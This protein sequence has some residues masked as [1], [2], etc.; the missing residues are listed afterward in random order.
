MPVR[1]LIVDSDEKTLE[2][3]RRCLP[4]PE[5]EVT[6]STSFGDAE[7]KISSER[8]DVMICEIELDDGAGFDLLAKARELKPEARFV[9]TTS[10]HKLDYVLRALK[11]G[12]CD[13]LKKPVSQRDLQNAVN[14]SCKYKETMEEIDI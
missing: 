13:Y 11:L 5:Y 12:A 8:Y 6:I 9:M 10:N 4:C 3:L 14:V 7:K 1:I 2:G